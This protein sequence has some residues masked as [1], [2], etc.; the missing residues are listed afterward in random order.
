M[1]GV[2]YA[3]GAHRREIAFGALVTGCRGRKREPKPTP[4]EHG[5]RFDSWAFHSANVWQERSNHRPSS[6]EQNIPHL[7]SRLTMMQAI[8][9]GDI[10]GSSWL[11]PAPRAGVSSPV[12]ATFSLRLPV[13][14]PALPSIAGDPTFQSCHAPFQSTVGA[15]LRWS[16]SSPLTLGVTRT[17]GSVN[18]QPCSESDTTTVIGWS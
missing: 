14:A 13:L 11:A 10:R 2:T 17:H 9:L 5:T 6:R 1:T 7:A 16:V 8:I 3:R 15:M 4:S 12:T 18:Y